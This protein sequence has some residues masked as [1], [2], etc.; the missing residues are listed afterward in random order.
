MQTRPYERCA[1]CA[2]WEMF[3][4][5]GHTWREETGELQR[6]P[7]WIPAFTGMTATTTAVQRGE[8]RVGQGRR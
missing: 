8:R 7:R 3:E 2:A 4:D 5:V 1:T 6:Q